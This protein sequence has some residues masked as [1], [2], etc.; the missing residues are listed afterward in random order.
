MPEHLEEDLGQSPDLGEPELYNGLELFTGQCIMC[1]WMGQ[2]NEMWQT[3]VFPGDEL[4]LA[5]Y[6]EREEMRKRAEPRL[7]EMHDKTGC[8]ALIMVI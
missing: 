3:M 4:P 1:R 5:S 6:E 7:Q 8:C 2:V